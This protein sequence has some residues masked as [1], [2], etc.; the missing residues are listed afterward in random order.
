MS[1]VR[2]AHAEQNAIAQAA[3]NGV[4]IEGGILYTTASCC[5]DCGKLVINA[6]IK[7]VVALETYPGRYGKSGTVDEM[8]RQAG[9]ISSLLDREA[10][11]VVPT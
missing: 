1:C 4:R 7:M 2:T 3:R 5:Y 9:V 11:V 8:F 6:G 10:Q